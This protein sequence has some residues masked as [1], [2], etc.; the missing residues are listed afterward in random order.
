MRDRCD[1]RTLSAPGLL[2]LARDEGINPE[3][4][5]AIADKLDALCHGAV[6]TGFHFNHHDKETTK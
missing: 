2:A 3:M 5:I 6:G 4:A 1:Y